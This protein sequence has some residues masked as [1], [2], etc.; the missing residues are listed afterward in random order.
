M[1][2]LRLDS[3][4]TLGTVLA[5]LLGFLMISSVSPE[6]LLQHTIMLILSLGLLFYLSSTDSAVF[7]SFAPL[8]YIGG[9]LLLIVTLLFAS[10]TRGTVSWIDIGNFRFQPSEF[11]KPLLILGFSYF[12]N[13]YPPQTI[14]HIFLNL[15]T[16]LLPSILIFIQ[17]DLGTALVLT[18]IWLVQIFVAGIPWRYVLLGVLVFTIT[19]PLLPH[20]LRDYQYARLTSF[21]DPYATPLTT[22]YNVIQSMIAV[23]SGGL[24]GKGLGQGTQSHLRF[25]PER[26]TD[27]AFASLAEELGVVGSLSV[28]SA[29]TLL[30]FR[31]LLRATHES[32]ATYRIFLSGACMYFAFQTFVNIGMNAGIAPITGIT[33]PLI[34][35]GGSSLLTSAVI[36]GISSSI[37]LRYKHPPLLEIR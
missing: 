7:L 5:M 32:H 37:I 14:F 30:V 35:Y 36:L 24:T 25:L 16:F 17:P 8:A 20:I 2:R 27:F 33:L 29:L 22:G 28:L 15:V 21:L 6:R 13:R 12:L 1:P 18:S 3:L 31:L 9:I 26:H 19:I 10:V 4:L 34:S 11:S 23:G